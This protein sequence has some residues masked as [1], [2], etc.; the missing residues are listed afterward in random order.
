MK[1]RV[2]Y[3][4]ELLARFRSALRFGS[5]EPFIADDILVHFDDARSRATLKLLAEF[6]ETTQVLLFT[7]HQAVG[8]LASA[9]VANDQATFIDLSADRTSLSAS[10]MLQA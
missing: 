1:L 8:R 9:L 2:V 4:F 6:A 7:H 3:Q 10:T 5:G